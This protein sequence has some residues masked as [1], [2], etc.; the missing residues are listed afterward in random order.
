MLLCIHQQTAQAAGYVGLVYS[1]SQI[2]PL[3][4]LSVL[5]ISNIYGSVT[6]LK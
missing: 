3:K 6:A 1:R 5:R 2:Y 4:R